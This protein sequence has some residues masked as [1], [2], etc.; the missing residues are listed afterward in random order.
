MCTLRARPALLA[1]LIVG[2]VTTMGLGFALWSD[3]LD[4]DATVN[5]GELNVRLDGA[6][7]NEVADN[8][9]PGDA[10]CVGAGVIEPEGNEATVTFTDAFPG[11]SCNVTTFVRNIGTVGAV[12]ASAN[13]TGDD[14]RFDIVR[15][16]TGQGGAPEG[17]V[18][19]DDALATAGPAWRVTFKAS[20][21]NTT[22][23]QA[24][25]LRF[26]TNFGNDAP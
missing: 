12:L 7:G 6:S 2:V 1:S 21:D 22:E 9:A 14:A 26:L 25:T 17:Q 5:T 10:S 11:H 18:Y 13:V 19:P 3:T 20:N 15:L 16:S 4:V 8:T 24:Y 23:D